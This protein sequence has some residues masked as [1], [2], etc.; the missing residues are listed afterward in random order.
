M[1]Q[2]PKLNDLD[3]DQTDPRLLDALASLNQIGA[4]INRIGPR[5]DVLS[6]LGRAHLTDAV[7]Q[8]ALRLI[9]DS[10]IKVVPG[11]SA[12][13]YTYD[14]D[15]QAFDLDSRVSAGE[16]VD[17]IS[18]DEPRLD[19]SGMRAI[20]Q[21]RRVLS[22]EE[23]DLNVHP[24]RA[25]AGVETLAC[26]PLIV[27][28]QPVGALYVSL[29]EARQFSPFELLIL[30]NFCNQ[31]A[32][33]IYHTRRLASVQR[34]L[35]RR[36][37][38]LSRLRYAGMLI[39][40]RL[41][42]EEML[43]AILDM[44]LQVTDARYGIFRLVD[45]QSHQLVARA[46]VGE[47]VGPPELDPL[48]IDGSSI[49]GWVAGHR[50][51]LCIHD[52]Q[53]APWVL[54]YRPLYN[55]LRMRSELAVPLVG[56]SGRLEGVL[57]LESPEIGTFSEHD[58]LLLQALA[59][60]AVIAIQEVRL[61]D[62]LQ[63]V[64]E[65]LLVRPCDDVLAY[66]VELACTL[67][68]AAASA[69]WMLDGDQLVLRVSSA[70]HRRG[71]RL[72]LHGSLTG[73]AVLT[74]NPVR[75]DDVRADERFH[76]TDLAR[77]QAWMSALIVPLMASNVGSSRE[78]MGAFSVYGTQD[79]PGRFV[80]SEWD[81]KVLTCLSHYA[82]LAVQNAVRQEA[83]H[84][85]RER[86]AVAETFAAVGDI[87]ANVLHHL[88]NK[89][90]TIPVRVQGI[91]DKC[92]ATLLADPYLSA[93]LD[94]IEHSA[95]EAMGAVRRN[96]SRLRPIHPAPVDVARSVQDAL[97]TIDLPQTISL[98]LQGLDDLPPVMAGTRSLS[99][100]F[101]N[102]LEN[103][104]T[105]MQGAGQIEIRGLAGDGWVEIDVTN[106]G[107]GIDPALHDRIFEFNYSGRRSRG[108]LGFG[109]WWVRSLLVRL[110]GTITVESDGVRGVTFRL[111][112]PRVEK[113]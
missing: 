101:A 47:D 72:P 10:A 27:A 56:A 76:R 89:V 64:A 44:A 74:N 53:A 5:A 100:V 62:A 28:D 52:L 33:A 32:M 35:A 11:A 105:A 61:L 70:G 58:S 7:V 77:E 39:S 2:M 95:R 1:T 22:Y 82:A 59:T 54:I 108:K 80:E 73:Q 97:R 30:E 45:E 93:N 42:L 102:L 51:P 106:D 96:L 98:R 103:A 38:E 9:V 17:A 13:I 87:A 12:V 110:G 24:A 37:E 8:Q 84:I 92:S 65:L 88:N 109:L 46:V 86:H 90:G 43:E 66:L 107:P 14:R 31:A 57:N 48:P 81:E 26:F 112:L 78:P 20:R 15:R 6:P 79:E 94:E 19:G 75:V 49:M 36:E 55:G 34:D 40:S 29:H 68:N 104:L 85:A 67:L 18:G 21:R 71:E 23:A 83:L 69:I 99:L 16:L 50:Q 113:T 25:R 41:R 91:H 60:Q 3:F 4:T 63:H 111:G